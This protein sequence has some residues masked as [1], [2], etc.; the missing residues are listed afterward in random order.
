MGFLSIT[1]LDYGENG[2]FSHQILQNKYCSFGQNWDNFQTLYF[3]QSAINR[4]QKKK[5]NKF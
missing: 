5:K 4:L 3:L 1:K 2:F